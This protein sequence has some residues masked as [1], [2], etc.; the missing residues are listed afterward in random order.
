MIASG[1]E[2]GVIGKVCERRRGNIYI[3]V[4]IYLCR[5][6]CIY[7]YAYVCVCM[8]WFCVGPRAGGDGERRKGKEE[9]YGRHAYKTKS[10]V[11]ICVPIPHKTI[12]THPH[13]PQNP[14][15]HTHKV[16]SGQ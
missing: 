12:T 2:P 5:Y 15:T 1:H 7:M 3:W 10:Y 11:Y 14:K 8:G 9:T 13:P 6:V 16:E 4:F